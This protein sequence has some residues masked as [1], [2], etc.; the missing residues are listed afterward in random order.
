MVD[1][2]NSLDEVVAS[3]YDEL[4]CNRRLTHDEPYEC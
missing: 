1:R 2:F 3:A 4:N